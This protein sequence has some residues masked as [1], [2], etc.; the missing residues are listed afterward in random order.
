MATVLANGRAYSYADIRVNINGFEPLSISKISWKKKRTKTNNT[1]LGKYPISRGYGGYEYEAE[2]EM[3]LE[4]LIVLEQNAPNNDI[5]EIKP[6]PIV[7]SWMPDDGVTVTKTLQFCEF[8]ES[9][10]DTSNGDTDTK[11]KL[12]LIIAGIKNG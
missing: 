9:G 1:G 10:V 8:T 2:L 4:D 6:F 5:E 7:V 3:S 12:P 11:V